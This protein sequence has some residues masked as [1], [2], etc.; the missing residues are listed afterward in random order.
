MGRRPCLGGF[1]SRLST[2]GHLYHDD[3]PPTRHKVIKRMRTK[4]AAT[5][6][7]P[8]QS[9]KHALIREGEV[10]FE[11]AKILYVGKKFDGHVD[12]IIDATGKLV[13]PG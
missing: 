7:V 4:I 8:H 13:A 5:W 10:V 12:K 11:D 2:S 9:G 1:G 3:R 6:I